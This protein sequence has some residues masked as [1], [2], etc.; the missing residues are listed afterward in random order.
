MIVVNAAPCVQPAGTSSASSIRKLGWNFSS[1]LNW[2]IP[3]SR[4]YE[5]AIAQT[6]AGNRLLQE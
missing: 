3:F 1:K 2:S 4:V 5:V 6:S